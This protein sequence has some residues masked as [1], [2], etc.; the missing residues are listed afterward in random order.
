MFVET[1]D[2]G[3]RYQAMFPS[4]CS[5]RAGGPFPRRYR[6]GKTPEGKAWRFAH[7]APYD[8]IDYTYETITAYLDAKGIT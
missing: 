2:L 3:F 4:G 8:E 1:D 7:K 6:L 5:P